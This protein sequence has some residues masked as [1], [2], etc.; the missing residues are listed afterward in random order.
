[1]AAERIYFVRTKPVEGQP[2]I[3]R[4]VRAS[5][6]STALMHVASSTYTVA[7]ATQND[8]EELLGKGTKVE[9][10]KAEQQEL[11]T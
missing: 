4:L 2:T 9:N 3:K 7:V 10:I 6:P 11:P 8:L 5:H 1:M